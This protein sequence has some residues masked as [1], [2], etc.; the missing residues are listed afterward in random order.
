MSSVRSQRIFFRRLGEALSPYQLL[1]AVLRFHIAMAQD[2]IQSLVAGRVPFHY[3][4]SEYENLSLGRLINVYARHSDNPPLI[5]RLRKAAA[6]RNYI[7]HRVVEEYMSHHEAKPRFAAGISRE[8]KKLESDGQDLVE[9]ALK[10][11]RVL[12]R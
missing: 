3:S 12:S 11:L 2:K 6:K 5:E 10:E 8:L 1:E 4:P 7:A 9:E